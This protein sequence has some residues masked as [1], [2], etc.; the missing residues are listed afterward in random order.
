MFDDKWL[1]EHYKKLGKPNPHTKTPAQ[2]STPKPNK[3]GAVRA[4]HDGVLFDS[5]KE[6]SFY[7]NLKLRLMAHDIKGFLYHGKF[8]LIEGTDSNHRAKTY[9]PDFII[10]HN[11]YSC[12]IVDTKGVQTD[13]FKTI[14]K[15][16]FERYPE[17]NIK[18]P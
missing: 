7:N 6:V 5:K 12:E 10:I 13:S 18:T 1:E 8:I 16:L 2:I 3:Y 4:W 14:L 11:D 9:E 17:V 15:L